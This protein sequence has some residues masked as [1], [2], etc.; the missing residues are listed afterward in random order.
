MR[1]S[2]LCEFV[3]NDTPEDMESFIDAFGATQQDYNEALELA[4]D[5][6]RQRMTAVLLS[7]V[8]TNTTLQLASVQVYS[9]MSFGV[10]NDML[11]RS[12]NDENLDTMQ[13]LLEAGASPDV[14][15]DDAHME[16][17][18]NEKLIVNATIRGRL[19][20]VEI[21]CEYGASLERDHPHEPPLMEAVL[22]NQYEIADVMLQYGYVEEVW[23]QMKLCRACFSSFIHVSTLYTMTL[24]EQV[25]TP[26]VLRVMPT[27]PTTPHGTDP[28]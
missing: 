18:N 25:Q 8:Y 24:T 11:V 3:E 28:C 16:T 20:A 5:L 21:L 12:Y 27:T 4:F 15:I 22:H 2:I 19:G 26:R 7:R 6:D 1:R 13:T 23:M 10:R 14:R 17:G 9:E